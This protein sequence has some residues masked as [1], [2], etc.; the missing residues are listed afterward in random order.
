VPSAGGPPSQCFDQHSSEDQNKAAGLQLGLGIGT[1]NSTLRFDNEQEADVKMSTVS[2]SAGRPVN[3]KWTVR[4]GLGMILDGDLQPDGGTAHNAESGGLVSLGVEYHALIGSGFTPFIDF[5]LFAGGSWTTT[6][7]EN[8]SKKISYFASDVRL[9]ARAVWNVKG[10]FFPYL[11]VRVF[12]GP[13]N[14]KLNGEDV[15]GSD[16]HHYQLALGAAV[17]FGRTGIYTEWA[18]AGEQALSAGLSMTF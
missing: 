11:T 14:W 1:F 17:Q 8:S 13:V 2:I 7:A 9:G 10:S 12:G 4:A 15:T 16:I 5:S 3:D 6:K 18:A